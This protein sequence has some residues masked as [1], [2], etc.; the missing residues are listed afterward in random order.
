MEKVRLFSRLEFLISH[1]DE[2]ESALGD[3]TFEI[4]LRARDRLARHKKLGDHRVTQTKGKVDHYVNLE[5]P[6]AMSVEEGHHNHRGGGWV[7]G[8]EIVQ[9]AIRAG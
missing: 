8:L 1:T 4:T 9:G 6:A 5:G 3:A 7:E 2:V